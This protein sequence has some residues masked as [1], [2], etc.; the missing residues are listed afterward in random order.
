MPVTHEENEAYGKFVQK[1]ARKL[2]IFD[3]EDQTILWHY[4][5]GAGLLGIL[6][7][8]HINATQVS[9]LNDSKETKFATDLYIAA[10]NR[11]LVEHKS[12]AVTVSFLNTV[13]EIVK[14]PPESPTQ[15]TSKFFV[16]CFSAAKDDLNQ[17][18][19][20]GSHDQGRYAIGFHARGL[21]RELNSSLHKVIYDRNKL[22]DAV[23][24]I[25][26]ATVLF[27]DEG[28]RSDGRASA[29]DLWAREFFAAWDEWIYKLAPVAKDAT[30]ES[31]REYRIVHELRLADMSKVRFSQ[32]RTMLSRYIALDFPCWVKERVSRLPIAAL[33]IGP[34]GHPL[35]TAVSARLL[36]DQ[37]GY[38]GVPV[39][40]STC[41]L[42]D[43]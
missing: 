19:R 37:M 24:K 25:A 31:E 15:G 6:Q 36:L 39:E 32:K 33:V 38:A 26:E 35:L 5:D 11:L 22:E 7:S 29:P 10:I 41:T 14:D 20:Y 8:G 12:E 18:T 1:I 40:V 27:F 28:L 16:A 42:T 43:R 2:G 34:K 30:W 13:L 17:W 3:F 4:T 23:N 9:A 21:N